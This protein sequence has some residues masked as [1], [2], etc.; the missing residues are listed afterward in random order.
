MYFYDLNEIQYRPKR[1]GVRI[2]GISG[3][4][5]QMTVVELA[6]GFA[7]DHMHPQEQ[8]GYILSGELDVTIGGETKRCGAGCAYFIPANLR[9]GFRVISDQPA[10]IM[11]IFSP[12]KDEN[13]EN[14]R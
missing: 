2:K 1:E 3:E 12:P 7:S 13:R 5:V 10:E 14:Q 8:M 6:P 4:C 9:H 11:D